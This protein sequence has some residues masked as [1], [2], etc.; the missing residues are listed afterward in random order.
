MKV[1]F[2]KREYA[3]LLDMIYLAD[4]M[5]HAHVEE[6]EIHDDYSALEQNILSHAREFGCENKIVYDAKLEQYFPTLAYEESEQI[7]GV[8]D[9]YNDETFWDELIERLAERDVLRKFG[10]EK[11]RSMSGEERMHLFWEAE[12]PYADE[13]EMNGLDRLKIEETQS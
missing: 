12:K 6:E 9:N 11:L 8:I 10:Q 2:T 13:F 4:W 3:A 1:N 5:L 7:H